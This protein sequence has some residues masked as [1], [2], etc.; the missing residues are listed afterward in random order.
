MGYPA[1]NPLKIATVLGTRPEIIKLSPLLP[2]LDKEFQHILIHTG[3][4]YDYRMDKVFFDELQLEPP[5]YNLTIGSHPAGKQTAMMLENIEEVLLK[6]K[7]QLVIVQGDTNSTLAGAL[8]AAKLHISVLHVEAG[9]RSFNRKMP[10]EINRVIV[11]HLSS[12]LIAP[13]KASLQN[14][15]QE[16]ITEGVNLF[17]SIV[18]DALERNEKLIP[19]ENMLKTQNISSGQYVLVTLHRAETTDDK[20][21]LQEILAALETIS[22][23][24]PVLFP[25]HPRTKKAL[26]TFSISLPPTIHLIEPQGY[27][28]FLALLKE[29]RFC[30]TDSG[31]I[32]EEAIFFNVP[33]L[34]P[35]QET[36]WISLVDAGKNILAGTTTETILSAARRLLDDKELQK[37]KN[38]P[39]PY[40]KG[41]ADNIISLLRSL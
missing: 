20:N 9:C 8:A 19:S 11:D 27:L 35:R 5:S 21:K 38:I 18:F 41:V 25:I 37:I 17:G 30:V 26:E 13:D 4:H 23:N 36:E 2:L 22:R 14:L 12:F 34:I 28:Q 16:G 24:L 32:Q 31:G 29:C 33:C 39:Y 15:S 40:E 6:E 10:E 1:K 7:P 3:Q